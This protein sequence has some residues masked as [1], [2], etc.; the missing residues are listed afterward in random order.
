MTAMAWVILEQNRDR[1][2]EKGDLMFMRGDNME[3]VTWVNR[4]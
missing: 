2:E 4:R 3:A 1:L